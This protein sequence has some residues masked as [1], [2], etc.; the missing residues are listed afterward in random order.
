MKSS[1]WRDSPPLRAQGGE[2][3]TAVRRDRSRLG[4]NPYGEPR[5]GVNPM[6][7]PLT[8]LSP[9]SLKAHREALDHGFPVYGR[10]LPPCGVLTDHVHVRFHGS[11][12]WIRPRKGSRSTGAQGRLSPPTGRRLSPYRRCFS[13]ICIFQL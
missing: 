3:G 7:K 9:S 5:R 11:A 1:P 12:R 10:G 6:G 13:L 4:V 8:F 2:K